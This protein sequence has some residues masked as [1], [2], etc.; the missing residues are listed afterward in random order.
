MATAVVPLSD[1]I[2]LQAAE[3]EAMTASGLVIPE[4]AKEK[5]Q[6]GN[7]IA[8]GPGK[9]NDA[10]VVL[11]VTD[12]GEGVPASFVPHLFERFSQANTGAGRSATGFGL[13]LAISAELAHVNGGD[14]RYEPAPTGG[15]S[16]VLTLPASPA[17]DG[18]A[19]VASAGAHPA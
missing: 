19:P 2:V 12:H 7:V 17:P 11:T 16:F 13:G 1:H 5:P 14:L 4:S 9:M 8:V 10:G 18:D 15:A 6:H 3:E